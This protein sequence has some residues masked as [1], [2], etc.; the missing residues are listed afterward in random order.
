MVQAPILDGVQIYNNIIENTG[1]DGLQVKSTPN[2]NCDIFNN[3]VYR[4]SQEN[5]DAQ[6]SGIANGKGG[7]CNIYNNFVKNGNSKGIRFYVYN[8][9]VIRDNI[10]IEPG[11]QDID[12]G[13]GIWAFPG[14]GVSGKRV[15]I[16]HN[17]IVNPSAAGIK[18]GFL[19]DSNT[20]I[21]NNLI[22]DQEKAYIDI[23]ADAQAAVAENFTT[24]DVSQVMFAD[25]ENDNYALLPDSPAVGF[26]ANVQSIAA[27]DDKT[28]QLK[29]I[30]QQESIYPGDSL[31]LNLRVDNAQDLYGLQITCAVDPT[32]LAWENAQFGDFFSAPLIGASEFD[33]ETGIWLGAVSQKFPAAPLAGDGLYAT[34]EFKVIGSGSAKISCEP[35]ASDKDG[36]ELAMLSAEATLTI[37]TI[38]GGIEGLV[39]YQ[40]RTDHAGIAV[41]VEGSRIGSL[42]TDNSGKFLTPDLNKGD[43]GF[44]ADAQLH[45]PSCT[46]VTVVGGQTTAIEQTFLA[47]GDTDDNDEIRIN[48]ATL[49]GSNFGLSS[50]SSPAMNAKADINADGEVDVKDLAIFGGNFGKQG[51][52][53]WFSETA[54]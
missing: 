17:T 6:R 12:G 1:W 49:I 15:V 11:Q 16:E 10:V 52:Q 8:D 22:V 48:D 18:F 38:M 45:L 34:F 47:G 28:T 21:Q 30:T 50:Q 43:Y 37:D 5:R 40:G 2:G 19:K 14:F 7:A 44:R 36:F 29:I 20:I 35:L 53:D 13:N 9:V 3:W 42:L 51:C 32:V 33:S 39:A 23:G 24:R 46:T 54:Q 41:S 25:P 27:D 4:D 26:G 31:T